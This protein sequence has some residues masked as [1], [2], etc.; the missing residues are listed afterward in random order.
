MGCSVFQR[1]KLGCSN[2]QPVNNA[3]SQVP[4]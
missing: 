2:Y 1:Y 4:S 3:A